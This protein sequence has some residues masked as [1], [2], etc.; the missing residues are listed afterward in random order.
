MITERNKELLEAFL[1]D[2]WPSRIAVVGPPRSGKSEV[3]QFISDH[4][5]FQHNE[6]DKYLQITKKE[7][8]DIEVD[9]F[10]KAERTFTISGM[11]LPKILRRHARAGECW[12]DGLV[13]CRTSEETLAESYTD[14]PEKV[15]GALANAKAVETILSDWRK[16]MD[17]ID[18]SVSEYHI[19]MSYE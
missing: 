3:S 13:V 14:E 6:T 17:G 5:G 11:S 8:R 2:R 1:K 16:L 4:M 15:K 18:I 7:V 9:K 10:I 19:D 12:I